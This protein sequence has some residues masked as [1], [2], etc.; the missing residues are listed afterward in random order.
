M[1][2]TQDRRRA[3]SLI[4]EARAA[5]ARLKP[6]CGV[7]GITARTYQRWTQGGAVRADGRP[8]A[9]RPAP[10]H[11]LTEDERQ[12]VLETTL[13][14]DYA[15]LPP[16]QIVPRL[17]DQGVYLASESTFYR[18]L[19]AHDLQHHRGRAK[20]PSTPRPP[21]T[22]AA[23]QPNQVWCWDITWL[24][25][26]IRGQFYFL[27][28]IIDLYSR[29]IVGWEVH[30][31]ESSVHARDLVERTVWRE[32]ILDQPLVLHGDNGSPLKGATVQALL[33]R[34]GITASFSRPRVSDDNAYAEALFRTLK[35]SPGFPR[36]GFAALETARDWV[37]TFADWYNTVHRHRGIKYVTPHQ[38]H[39][40]EDVGILRQRHELYDA[41][42]RRHPARWSGDTRNWGHI[43]E[44]WLNPNDGQRRLRKL[45]NFKRHVA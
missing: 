38:R 41:A 2:S 13:Q 6:S 44:V 32:G 43:R 31:V 16:G 21:T 35:Y 3:V 12:A 34:L 29:K 4:D 27:Y 19:R 11:A 1:I 40:G 36:H 42:R 18:V 8:A 15:D 14:P 45:N 7:L 20:A 24:P 39:S 26:P 28:L 25:G 37:H 22:H 23:D 9:V 17:A 30:E 5:G 10:S 33:G